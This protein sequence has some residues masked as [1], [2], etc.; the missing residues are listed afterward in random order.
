MPAVASM[1]QPVHQVVHGSV[2]AIVLSFNSARYLDRCL[3]SLTQALDPLGA[4]NEVWVVENG[5]S[6]AS[7]ELLRNWAARRPDLVRPIYSPVNLG[8][9]A[10]RN[11]A[12]AQARGE[13]LL[14]LD[15]DAYIDADAL[16]TL[17]DHLAASP[18]VGLVAPL[19]RYGDGRFQLSVDEFPTFWRKL[20]RLCALRKLER[21]HALPSQPV[22]V[23]YAISA[24]WLLPMHVAR[25]VGPLDERIFYSPEDVDYCVRIGLA[26]YSVVYNP[27][28]VAV[29]DAQELSRSKKL[30]G[31]FSRHVG[32]LFYLYFKHHFFLSSRRL[33]RRISTAR[34]AKHVS[35]TAK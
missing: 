26:G 28:S 15:S 10:S 25:E 4:N 18:A 11:R 22:E 3:E 7:P 20:V 12:L 5:S 32:G 2:S 29:H 21:E 27:S 30:N 16:R 1:T 19:L 9:T 6:D 13:Y 23:D 8:T 14:V 17:R 31:F 34:R 24:C 35:V 33:V